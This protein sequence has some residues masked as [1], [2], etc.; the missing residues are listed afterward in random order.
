MI[1]EMKIV[2]FMAAA[3]TVSAWLASAEGDRVLLDGVVAMVNE[4]VITVGD[5]T[6]AVEPL[7]RRIAAPANS[8]DFMEEVR[9]L[10]DESRDALIQKY[11]ILDSDEAE[12]IKIPDWYIDRRVDEI[13]KDSFSGDRTSFMNVLARDRQTFEQ[14]RNEL[15][16][17]ILVSSIRSMKID[18]NVSVSP[19]EVAGYYEAEKD[20]FVVPARVRIGMIILEKGSGADD[21]AV[22]A[23]M[24]KERIDSGEDFAGLARKYSKGSYAEKGGDWGWIDPSIL[25]EDI[26]KA[27]SLLKTGE[28]G[29]VE[30]EGE[31]YLFRVVDRQDPVKQAFKDVQVVV[32]Q[33][34]KRKKADAECRAWVEVLRKRAFVKVNEMELE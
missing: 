23:A 31:V 25:R 12:K 30:G 5:I 4:H 18:Q 3:L 33:E 7:K 6:S 10:Y 27:T 15:R 24:L 34:L 16:D 11:L 14:W 20:R 22:L 28:T 13:I 9:R 2:G 19:V 1:R 32:E 17:H 26:M 8:P 29:I 21:P